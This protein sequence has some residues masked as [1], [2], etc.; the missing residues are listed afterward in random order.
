MWQNR[1]NSIISFVGFA[2]ELKKCNC[3]ILDSTVFLDMPLL[4]N[5]PGLG[6]WQGCEYARAEISLN[7][8]E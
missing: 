7:V 6:I 5:M 4:R 1:K 3:G 2:I 8:S